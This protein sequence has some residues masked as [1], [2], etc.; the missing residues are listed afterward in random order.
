[1]G[2]IDLHIAGGD[3]EADRLARRGYTQVLA[4]REALADGPVCT[5]INELFELRSHFV[6]ESYGA[7]VGLYDTSVRSVF[8]ELVLQRADRV[9]L[10]FDTDLFCTVNLMFLVT[11]LRKVPELIW[12]TR[13]EASPLSLL[14]RVFLHSCWHA[15]AGKDPRVL[16]GLI[17]QAPMSMRAFVPSMRLHLERF[18]ST[19]S[20]MGRP[21]EMVAELF[22]RGIEDDEALISAFIAIDENHYGWGDKQILREVSWTRMQHAGRHFRRDVGG[23]VVESEMPQWRWDPLRKTILDITD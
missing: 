7:S 12:T 10:H 5:D 21:Q 18:P 15:Y 16:E 9:H 17:E 20:G 2:S 19:T 8:D 11:H 13:T 14:D 22:D 23:C 4:W 6:H 1:M 3:V